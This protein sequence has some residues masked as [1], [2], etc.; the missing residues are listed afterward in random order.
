MVQRFRG[1]GVRRGI[2][3]SATSPSWSN[4]F[5]DVGTRLGMH[6]TA[7]SPSFSVT[8]KGPVPEERATT[9]PPRPPFRS[10][11][12]VAVKPS[13]TPHLAL[14]VLRFPHGL[15][16]VS[17]SRQTVPRHRRLAGVVHVFAIAV[18]AGT[19]RAVRSPF[20]GFLASRTPT[21][22]DAVGWPP[23][24]GMRRFLRYTQPEDS[25]CG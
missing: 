20:E 17:P 10:G 12:A 16:G 13:T 25:N 15:V 4:V 8:T 22:D 23:V 2:H 11:S 6:D 18:A 7:T 19:Q 24:L 5:A 1:R 21:T 14:V 9:P 3:N